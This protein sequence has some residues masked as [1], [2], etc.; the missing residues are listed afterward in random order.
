[1]KAFVVVGILLFM[2]A[3]QMANVTPSCPE[4]YFNILRIELDDYGS[5]LVWAD[6]DCDDV[7]DGAAMVEDGV[8]LGF[9][10]CEE[11]DGLFEEYTRIKKSHGI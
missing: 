10:S 2:G 3:C 1:M 5:A 6:I 9:I 4:D 8:P 7:C 11:A